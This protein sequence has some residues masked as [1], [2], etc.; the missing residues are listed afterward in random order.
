MGIGESGT[1]KGFIISGL[2]KRGVLT[3]AADEN[4]LAKLNKA[5][6]SGLP[7]IRVD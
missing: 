1:E 2:R 3:G 5:P 7:V 4:A 6:I